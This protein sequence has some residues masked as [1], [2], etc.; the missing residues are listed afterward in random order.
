MQR[1][2]LFR[3]NN[4]KVRT[5]NLLHSYSFEDTT[6]TVIDGFGSNNGSTQV[7]MVREVPGIKGK[8]FYN[9]GA[10][11]IDSLSQF[12][13]TTV[14]TINLWVK[15][16][17]HIPDAHTFRRRGLININSQT[18]GENLYPD[19]DGNLYIGVLS[20]TRKNIGA[21]IVTDRTQWHM[22]TV[23]SNSS[24]GVW[25]FY[26]NAQLVYEG[27]TGAFTMSNTP[28]F[29]TSGSKRLSGSIDELRIWNAELTI[30]DIQNEY[31]EGNGITL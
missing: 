10:N 9:D 21:G 25:K 1:R 31:N 18:G 8:C 3:G 6:T 24:T 23:T 22:V 12:N 14:G 27:T 4:K 2:G 5:E 29:Y 26:Q 19:G 17:Q 20:D 28:M 13:I 15:L 16:D 7:G 11:F 30:T